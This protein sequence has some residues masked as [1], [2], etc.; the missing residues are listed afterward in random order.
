[1]YKKN[2]IRL[3]VDCESTPQE[4][5]PYLADFNILGQYLNA[6]HI[7]VED[8]QFGYLCSL[9]N[10]GTQ[11]QTWL[12]YPPQWVKNYWWK[13]L[14]VDYENSH[15]LMTCEEIQ[16]DPYDDGTQV[17]YMLSY[18][19]KSQYA[20]LLLKGIYLPIQ[21]RRIKRCI[22][23]I[24]D[25]VARNRNNKRLEKISQNTTLENYCQKLDEAPYRDIPLADF[26]KETNMS[27]ELAEEALVDMQ[28]KKLLNLAIKSQCGY[29]GTL[30]GLHD[31]ITDVP[32][33]W[34]CRICGEKTRQTDNTNPLDVLIRSQDNKK[35][36][37]PLSPSDASRNVIAHISLEAN[38]EIYTPNISLTERV[39]IRVDKGK[40]LQ[41]V[42][43]LN[44]LAN[45]L[46]IELHENR[47]RIKRNDSVK[48]LCIENLKDRVSTVTILDDSGISS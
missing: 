40:A 21:L 5:W 36:Y 8:R 41:Q 48:T 3:S 47:L 33:D 30:S 20:A 14:R 9:K 10:E 46:W 37:A 16:C 4:L 25:Y 1:M 45:G 42:V 22:K 39:I 34:V 29:C 44:P 43:E 38:D 19:A 11:T 18:L 31:E 17:H 6:P 13:R 23:Q 12:E 27:Y 28:R 24:D 7:H 35:I 26:C 2:T 32:D 15:F